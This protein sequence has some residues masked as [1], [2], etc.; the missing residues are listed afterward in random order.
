MRLGK[1]NIKRKKMTPE[2]CY[3]T[4]NCHLKT[5]LS[6]FKMWFKCCCVNATTAIDF[7]TKL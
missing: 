1:K 2:D 3:K 5:Q 7:L 6:V 4:E